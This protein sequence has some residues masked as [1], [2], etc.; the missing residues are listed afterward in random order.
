MS[1]ML[2]DLDDERRALAEPRWW[3]VSGFAL[4]VGALFFVASLTPSL[5]PRPA[6]LQGAL[7]GASAAL[8]YAVGAALLWLWRI[9][10]LPEA[11]DDDA[12]RFRAAFIV[13]ALALCTL[14]LWQAPDWQNATRRAMELPPVDTIHPLVVAP[15]AALVFALLW[16]VG[17]A[18]TMVVRRAGRALSRVLPGRVGPVI[19][20]ALAALLFWSLIE[21]VLVRRVMEAADASF[22]AA[23]EVFSPGAAAPPA[24]DMTGGVES[25]ITWGELGNRGR[26]FVARTPTAREIGAFSGEGAMRPVRVYVGRVSAETARERAELALEEL[27]RQGGFDREILIVTTP[28]GTGWMDPGAHDTVDFMWGGDTAHVA[29]QYSYLTSVLSILTNVE[30]GL[31][32]ARAL[33]DVIHDHWSE[34]PEGERPALY[35]HGLSQGALN[36]QATLPLFDVL[37][38]PPAG[39]LWAGSPFVSPVWSAIRDGRVTGSP[40]WRPR[41]GN[42]SLVRVTNQENVLDDPAFAPWGPI[43]FVFLHYGSD[44]IVNASIADIW[45]APDWLTGERPPDVAP[46]MRWYPLVT[47]FQLMLD[48]TTALSVEGYGHFYVADDYIDAWAALTEPPGWSDERAA[49][50]K[51]LWS[52]RPP[53]W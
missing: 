3:R 46:E 47:A 7:S 50:L 32:Q 15:I 25:L 34:L 19:G 4:A 33:F 36:S 27:I 38:D 26:D 8:G 24:T 12:R 1:L 5:I 53:P 44:P 21:G 35:I 39:A 23:E 10:R 48:M 11:D 16:L 2:D 40:E 22:A 49:E 51:A 18:F 20:F 43:R 30:Y 37:A 29:A 9:M 17:S 14:G 41:F 42:G 28:V 6:A 31:D 13:I 52:M 45:R